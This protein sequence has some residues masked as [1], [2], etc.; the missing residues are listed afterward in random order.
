MEETDI[1]RKKGRK[2]KKKKKKKKK[3]G[4]QAEKLIG[5]CHQLSMT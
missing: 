4:G 1:E 2:K 5:W 3:R